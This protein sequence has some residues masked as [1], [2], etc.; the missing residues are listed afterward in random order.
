M[1]QHSF[2]HYL[3]LSSANAGISTV[4]AEEE[5]RWFFHD[6]GI[7]RECPSAPCHCLMGNGCLYHT[8][9]FL[10]NGVKEVWLRHKKYLNIYALPHP[11]REKE[12]Q[13]WSSHWINLISSQILLAVLSCVWLWL[14]SFSAPCEGSAQLEM[15]RRTAQG[16]LGWPR[17]SL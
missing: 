2:I 7:R 11:D 3:V 5:E 12:A 10:S 14:V 15:W 13:I 6:Y 17:P 16:S 8:L 4:P 1:N 9:I